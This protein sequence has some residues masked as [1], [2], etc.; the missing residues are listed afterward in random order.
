MSEIKQALSAQRKKLKISLWRERAYTEAWA[1]DDAPIP[2]DSVGVTLPL[3]AGVIRLPVCDYCGLIIKHPDDCVMHEWLIRRA[4]L[5]VKLQHK[6]MTEFNCCLLHVD[7]HEQHETTARCKMRCAR[8]QY[9]RYGRDKIAAWVKSLELRQTVWI[10]TIEEVTLAA[11]ADGLTLTE[12]FRLQV[13]PH[14]L[15]EED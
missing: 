5:P 2:V 13:N 1:L 4:A 3:P 7:C 8:A 10:P 6:I 15:M 11:V 12:D 9:K 14:W